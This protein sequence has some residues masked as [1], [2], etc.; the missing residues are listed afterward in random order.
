MADGHREL[1]QPGAA[2]SG[3]ESQ[4]RTCRYPQ[5]SVGFRK[6]S[7]SSVA[8]WG[9]PTSSSRAGD[10]VLKRAHEAMNA[11]LVMTL[12]QRSQGTVLVSRQNKPPPRAQHNLECPLASEPGA[13]LASHCVA[14]L[15]LVTCAAD[16]QD[17]FLALPFF[18]VM[19]RA[20]VLPTLRCHRRPFLTLCRSTSVRLQ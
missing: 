19:R 7:R 1:V 20:H 5:S 8:R 16:W 17:T 3:C 18:D 2:P 12:P 9:T 11:A 14:P 6:T 10:M 13:L 15:L 4:S